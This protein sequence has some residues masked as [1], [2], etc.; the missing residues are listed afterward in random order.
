[1]RYTVYHRFWFVTLLGAAV[2][3]CAPEDALREKLSRLD[4]ACLDPSARYELI[5][6]EHVKEIS[7]VQDLH[8]RKEY[9]LELAARLGKLDLAGCPIDVK[10]RL[11]G[12]YWRPL[13]MLSSALRNTGV[14]E[15]ELKNVLLSIWRNYHHMCISD[16]VA[17]DIGGDR[18]SRFREMECMRKLRGGYDNDRRFFERKLL[19]LLLMESGL[20]EPSRKRIMDVWTKEF[21]DK[22]PGRSLR[23]EIFH[24]Q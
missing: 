15:D 1:M 21:C 6:A 7:M 18:Q 8:R 16:V 19:R 14:T 2:C 11:S 24:R 13:M 23:A 22:E 10:E 12:T 17:S 9:L 20:E 5:V 4:G 3:A